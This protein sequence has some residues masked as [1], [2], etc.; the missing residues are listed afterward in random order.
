MPKIAPKKRPRE[1]L[2]QLEPLATENVQVKLAPLPRLPTPATEKL[3]AARLRAVA[4]KTEAKA[5]LQQ[6]VQEAAAE[7]SKPDGPTATQRLRELRDRIR[8]KQSETGMA[9]SVG[10]ISRT[11]REDAEKR[12]HGVT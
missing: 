1:C 6:C 9:C 5:Q 11:S 2:K 4:R 8:S 12:D 3:C 7:A 10:G